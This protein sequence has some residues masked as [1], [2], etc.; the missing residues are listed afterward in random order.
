[1]YTRHYREQYV[2]STLRLT[3]GYLDAD[4][5]GFTTYAELHNI[6][7]GDL[8][9][10]FVQRNRLL[11]IADRSS[12]APPVDAVRA[13][14]ATTVDWP[15]RGRPRTLRLAPIQIA[16]SEQL[17]TLALEPWNDGHI[18]L[19]Q[20][21]SDGWFAGGLTTMA[22][23]VERDLDSRLDDEERSWLYETDD[24]RSLGLTNVESRRVLVAVPRAGDRVRT[25]AAN[26][27]IGSNRRVRRE[28]SFDPLSGK[29]FACG[30][31]VDLVFDATARRASDIPPG[32][33]A[34]LERWFH[35]E[36]G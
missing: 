6:D 9:A 26:V 18:A 20:C 36:L 19:G 30:D 24:G 7:S 11:A 17:R 14:R 35:P 3:G 32:F 34:E 16:S 28:W 15:E 12:V 33:R 21:D 4:D 27:V 1:V 22:W 13:A 23:G 5:D 2:G 8:A 10:T 29:V 31:F 25:V